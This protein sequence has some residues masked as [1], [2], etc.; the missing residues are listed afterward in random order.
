[1]TSEGV[2][3]SFYET[4]RI[5]DVKRSREKHWIDQS[6]NYERVL[7]DIRGG[8]WLLWR[9]YEDLGCE[10]EEMLKG[11]ACPFRLH[12]DR[13]LQT[14]WVIDSF[15]ELWWAL[16]DFGFCHQPLLEDAHRWWEPPISFVNFSSN[17]KFI[18]AGTPDYTL[19]C[20]N[21]KPLTLGKN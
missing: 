20:L 17:D 6:T 5:W 18:L 10:D 15:Q 12:D 19:V 14:G 9:D 7:N 8:F 1:M 13:S 16:Q 4:V 21:P 3:G 2:F 11:F